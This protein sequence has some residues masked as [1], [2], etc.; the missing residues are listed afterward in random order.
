MNQKHELTLVEPAYR[1]GRMSTDNPLAGA[2]PWPADDPPELARWE[3]SCG[4][5]GDSEQCRDGM[6]CP[7]DKGEEVDRG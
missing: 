7:N 2:G 6:E 4:W 5:T 1:G 3:C